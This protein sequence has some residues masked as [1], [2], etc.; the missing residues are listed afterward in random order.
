MDVAVAYGQNQ[1][2]LQVPPERLVAVRREAPPPPPGDPAAMVR[3]AV[4]TPTRFPPLAN[5]PTSSNSTRRRLRKFSSRISRR[6]TRP[7]GS[8]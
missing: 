7:I 2:S 1:L 8:Q 5:K 6:R 3:D 4:K